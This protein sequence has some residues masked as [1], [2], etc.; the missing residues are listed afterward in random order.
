MS[1]Q[2]KICFDVKSLVNEAHTRPAPKSCEEIERLFQSL[3]LWS[4]FINKSPKPEQKRALEL[5]MEKSASPTAEELLYMAEIACGKYHRI[6]KDGDFSCLNSDKALE[7]YK[8]YYELTESAEARFILDNF[9]EFTTLCYRSI[10]QRQRKDDLAPY[11]DNS[12][13]STSRDPDSEEW[14][15]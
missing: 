10:S 4:S 14:K 12:P 13:V 2:G 9:E 8:K 6:R 15:G 3:P 1:D 11:I 7:L 5:L